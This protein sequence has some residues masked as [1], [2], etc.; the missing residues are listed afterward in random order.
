MKPSLM[1][2][3]CLD[4]SSISIAFSSFQCVDVHC[5][6]SQDTQCQRRETLTRFSTFPFDCRWAKYIGMHEGKKVS[7]KVSFAIDSFSPS[8][9][10]VMAE[11]ALSVIVCE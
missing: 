8:P 2:Y 4:I 11:I 3:L 9:L 10:P 6:F 5:I 7:E 1:Q